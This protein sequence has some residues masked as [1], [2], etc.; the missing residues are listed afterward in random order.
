MLSRSADSIAGTSCARSSS[1]RTG[2]RKEKRVLSGRAFQDRYP[3]AFRHCFGCG[4]SNER[5]TKLKR[6]WDGEMT[7]ARFRP[8]DY[9]TGGVPGN[10]YGGL[11]AS[12]M[13]CHG[14]AS[15]AAAAAR[16]EGDESE[17]EPLQRY[18]TASLQVDFRRPTPMGRDL[19]VRARGFE[20]DGRK[21][22]MDLTLSADG[23]VCATG[24]M[25]AI[26]LRDEPQEHAT[27]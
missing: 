10:A 27:S 21:V 9:Y 20:I 6:H 3:E 13:D 14:T 8:P 19:E 23:Q 17:G 2:R 12:L 11:I 16:A 5:G 1:I 4:R 15:A 25:L 26:R 22:T 18:V 7:V 24:R